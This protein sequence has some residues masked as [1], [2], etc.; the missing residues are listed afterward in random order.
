MAQAIDAYIEVLEEMKIRMEVSFAGIPTAFLHSV[1]WQV[2]VLRVVLV[3]RWK[4]RT[5][6]C[7]SGRSLRE[8]RRLTWIIIF[9][10]TNP[11]MIYILEL[12]D[13]VWPKV[14]TSVMK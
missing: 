12:R 13:T 7:R 3:A 2:L 11:I 5:T 6:A 8:I 14:N 10:A 1:T 9:T 4:Q